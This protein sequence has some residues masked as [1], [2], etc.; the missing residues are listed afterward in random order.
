MKIIFIFDSLAPNN[1]R[2]YLIDEILFIRSED[3]DARVLTLEEED[4]KNTLYSDALFT[5]ESFALL[6]FGKWWNF[7]DWK[8]LKE[9]LEKEHPD[10][11]I[12]CGI[13]ADTIGRIAAKISR[14]PMKVFVFAHDLSEVRQRKKIYDD[15]F[16][17]ITD[18]YIVTSEEAKTALSR[19]EVSPEKI[20]VLQDG[21]RL[22][23]YGQPSAHD[24][25]GELGIAPDEFVFIFL[26]ELTS[27]KN[28]P[29]LLR[30]MAKVPV[31]RLII[32]GDGSAKSEAKTI[33]D[34]LGL[35]ERV[36]FL[37]SYSDIPG[38]LSSSNA[39]VI[40]SKKEEGFPRNI[41]LG[42]L[43][44]LPVIA[45]DF[46]GVEVLVKN[47]ENGIIVKQQDSAEMAR[48]MEEMTT[49]G[50][51]YESLRRNTQRD[52]EKYSL[53]THAIKLLSLAQK[54]QAK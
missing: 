16:S 13:K 11:V 7:K 2:K 12:T 41:L 42:L 35:S 10:L 31:G 28:I 4:M 8:K 17:H 49:N 27:E 36:I 9:Y 6:P 19:L 20:T 32:A 43:S 23:N 45:T 21:I 22:E 44:G 29:A 26:G 50:E 24:I 52:L 30:A 25:R 1:A 15:I 51:S 33:S 14:V 3:V 46:Y 40:S 54:T 39:M 5:K 53:A 18:Q 47:K 38:L 37:E 34:G 48:V